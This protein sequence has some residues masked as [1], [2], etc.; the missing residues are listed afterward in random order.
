MSKFRRSSRR[1]AI[2]IDLGDICYDTT[3]VTI[4]PEGLPET[5]ACDVCKGKLDIHTKK[6]VNKIKK[7]DR[8]THQTGANNIGFRSG[9][10]G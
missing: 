4:L 2:H 6:V 1:G 7:R 8:I 5:V 9:G 3:C 10:Q